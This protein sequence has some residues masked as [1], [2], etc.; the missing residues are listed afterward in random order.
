MKR[1]WDRLRSGLFVPKLLKRLHRDEEGGFHP[2]GN[3]FGCSCEEVLWCTINCDGGGPE[4]FQV[5]ISDLANDSCSDCADFN[6]TFVLDRVG[7]GVISPCIWRYTFP[8]AICGRTSVSLG[9]GGGGLS[10]FVFLGNPEHWIKQY[11]SKVNC[12]SLNN[13]SLS[14]DPFVGPVCDGA[15]SSCLV[16]AL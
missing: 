5:V 6:D 14:W 12:K 11:V 4:Q 7:E 15:A 16:T 13:E 3:W 8:S 9:V 1:Q 2:T 10:V